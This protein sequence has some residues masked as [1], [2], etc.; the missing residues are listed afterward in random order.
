METIKKEKAVKNSFIKKI[1]YIP[2]KLRLILSMSFLASIIVVLNA[3]VENHLQLDNARLAL[4]KEVNIANSVLE[5]DYIRFLYV[6]NADTASDAISKIGSFPMI[7]H[8]DLFTQENINLLH[9]SRVKH[10][11]HLHHFDIE[12]KINISKNRLLI[13]YPIRIDKNKI[14]E[15]RYSISTKAIDERAQVIFK[16]NVIMAI[17]SIMIAIVGALFINSLILRKESQISFLENMRKIENTILE[18]DDADNML[19]AVLK[20]IQEIFKSDRVYLV[21]PCNPNAINWTVDKGVAVPE[22][23]PHMKLGEPYEMTEDIKSSFSNA[24]KSRRVECFSSKHAKPI[25]ESV[26]RFSTQAE[27]HIALLPK[28]GDAWLFGIQQCSRPRKWNKDEIHLMKAISQRIT[29]GLNNLLLLRNISDSEQHIRTL[30]DSTAEGIYGLDMDGVCTFCNSASVK[31][32]GF[33]E[34]EELIGKTMHN[35]IHHTHR[36]GEIYNVDDCKIYQS[37]K[38]NKKCHSDSEVMF[39]ANGTSFDAEY[40]SYP[41]ERNGRVE[42]CVVT[43]LDVTNRKQQEALLSYQASHDELTGLYNRYEFE[44][45]LFQVLSQSSIDEH[46]ALCVFDLDQF[47]VIN[48]TCGHGAGDEFLKK[49]SE[50]LSTEVRRGDILARIGGDKFALIINSCLLDEAT[51]ITEKILDTINRFQFSWQEHVFKVGVSIGLITIEGN[52]LEVADLLMHADTACYAAKESG[53]NRVHLYTVEDSELAERQVEMRWVAR[54]HQAIKENQ[55]ILYAQAIVPVKSTIEKHYELLIRL[56]DDEGSIIAPGV[57]LPAAE[58]FDV[59]DH[60]DSWVIETSFNLLAKSTK[61]LNEINFI[62]INLSGKSL[63]TKSFPTKIINLINRTKLEPSKICFEITETAAITNLSVAI[64]F[65]NKLKEVGFRFALDDF[66]SG[67]SS[68]GYLKNLP[69]D[70]LKIDG[71]FVKD[72]ANDVIDLEMVKSINNIGHV[73]GMKTIAEFVENDEILN[74]LEVIGVDYAQG[75]GVGKPLPLSELL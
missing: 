40:W 67:L 61:F 69:V 41:I 15:V 20:V 42:G 46:H 44:R 6:D 10:E 22:Y 21:Y 75:Y 45:K 73:M 33:T 71:M 32:L 48:D 1:N 13:N 8:M 9:F 58:K 37:F 65:I 25:N 17:I 26:A 30:L 63:T 31:L 12:D 49:L 52:K 28:V 3:S 70:Y 7:L 18:K 39:R 51:L 54:I 27:M 53:R 35:L 74:K 36:N 56:Q 60:I 24:L 11:A 66:G 47:K 2:I 38:E 72:M 59:I 23:P 34:P 14:G 50:K 43:F 4:I 16:T 55:F 64:E 62:S 5:Q 68:F 19:S 57:F 29:E